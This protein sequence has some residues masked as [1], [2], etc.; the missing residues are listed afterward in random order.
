MLVLASCAIVTA[1]GPTRTDTRAVSGFTKIELSGSGDVTIDQ[2]GT[3]SLTIEA[4][5]KVLPH[6][7]S[8][9]TAD[10]LEL[11]T[12]GVVLTRG[13]PIR[14]HVTVKDLTGLSVSGSG[15]MTALKLSTDA[16]ES[17][18]SGSGTITVSGTA[19]DQRLTIS[20]SGTYDAGGLA[21]TTLHADISGSGN[22][23]VNVSDTIDVSVS[24]SGS[25]TYQGDPVVHQDISGSGRVTRR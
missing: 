16:F 24:G 21:G 18:I 17:D 5:E 14:Y 2:T 22:A 8:D 6:L 11:G 13:G 1:P 4:G 19:A 10:T 15:T 25:L 3:E 12:R 9:V 20:G 23:M 7:T